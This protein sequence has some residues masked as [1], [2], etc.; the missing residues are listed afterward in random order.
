VFGY[1]VIVSKT[2]K[3]AFKTPL[4]F[5]KGSYIMKS[6]STLVATLLLGT[7]FIFQE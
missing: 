6:T 7:G 3:L 2:V 1:H 4:I 5:L